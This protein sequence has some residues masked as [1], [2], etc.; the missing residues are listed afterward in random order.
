MHVQITL[1]PDPVPELTWRER[2][3]ALTLHWLRP[4]GTWRGITALV[5]AVAPIPGVGE[6]A[7]TVWHYVVS[8]A[9]GMSIG[10]GYAVGLTPVA[11]A[12]WALTRV[13]PTGPR[14][15]LLAVASIGALGAVSA[16]DVVQLLTGVT[17]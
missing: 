4:L 14:L 11:F 15:W 9:R 13:G 16:Y 6:S 5:L 12:G 17:R 2:L 8:E 10:A 3:T 1:T 7:A